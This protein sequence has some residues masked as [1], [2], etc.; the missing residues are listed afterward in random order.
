M[1]TN[2][3]TAKP[4]KVKR[5]DPPKGKGPLAPKPSG[6]F[7]APVKAPSVKDKPAPKAKVSKPTSSALDVLPTRKGQNAKPYTPPVAKTV[8]RKAKRVRVVAQHDAKDTKGNADR[9]RAQT[10]LDA[11]P[12]ILHPKKAEHHGGLLATIT[13]AGDLALKGASKAAPTV[14]AGLAPAITGT[15]AGVDKVTGSHTRKYASELVGNAPKDLAELVTTTPTSLVKLGDT[16]VHDPKKVPGLLAQPYKDL[17]KDPGKAI[18]DHPFSTALMLDPA[19]KAPGRIAGKVA[20]V[21]GKQTLKGADATLAGTVLK[22]NRA[23]SRAVVRNARQARQ[24]AK[25]PNPQMSDKDVHRRVDE[26]FDQSQQKRQQIEAAAHRTAKKQAEAL[27][28]DQR[29]AHI[30]ANVR[31][32]RKGSKRTIDQRFVKEFG[33]P[34]QQHPSGAIVKPKQAT[35]GHLHATKA[36]ADAVQAALTR[37]HPETEWK[38]M[39]AG[40]KFGVVPKVAAERLHRQRVVGT[41]KATGAVLLR[42]GR[43]NLTQATLP[44]SPKWLGGQASEAGIRAV[45]TGAGPADWLRMKKV[46]TK[47]NRD[48]PGSGDE[49]LTR[50]GGTHSGLVGHALDFADGK[51]TLIDA[52]GKD[53]K[54]AR[55]AAAAGKVAD[56]KPGRGVRKGWHAYT[57]FVLG[58]VN[59]AIEHNARIAIGG[60]HVQ[61]HL[62]DNRILSLSDKA[63][64]DAAKGLKGTAAQV[65]LGRM[66]DRDYGKYSK[67]S[68][69]A[70]ELILHST[71]Y[72]PWWFNTVHFLTQVLPGDHP[73]AAAL[74]GDAEEA[75]RHWRESHGLSL[76]GGAR[77]P[78]WMLGSYP[79]TKGLIPTG[80]LAGPF[81]IGEDPVAALAGTVLPQLTGPLEALGPGIDWTGQKLRVGGPHGKDFNM[82][83]KLLYAL[84]QAVESQAPLTGPIA[85][86]THLNEKVAHKPVTISTKQRA[87]QLWNPIAVIPN[88]KDDSASPGSGAVGPVP[89]VSQ[90][91]IDQLIREAS[92]PRAP[93]V[94]QREIDALLKQLGG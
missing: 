32:A 85:R 31:G 73:V 66:I 89:G 88:T 10:Y 67:M 30:A 35:E 16:A 69:K 23:R 58:R 12:E 42:A 40:S 68:P 72:A 60:H 27:P 46:V 93:V 87:N 34:W 1:Q 41:S 29:Q 65:Q 59:G 2:R 74:V 6:V 48:T 51:T 81:G 28:K 47:M 5:V 52:L 62:L 24:D 9:Q 84:T 37:N 49:L 54:L 61:Q 17:I 8:V 91:E 38:V 21:T 76:R 53:S 86:V 22:E 33:S 57:G 36:T 25:N 70:R 14:V 45:A 90:A 64:A 83:Q 26:F 13:G 20:R 15:L 94:S 71:P 11:H 78:N 39:K 75:E 43:R 19:I 80:K 92:G 79:T 63:V 82:G 7:A 44:T 3:A 18:K 56:S 77:K 50:L 4:I 55:P